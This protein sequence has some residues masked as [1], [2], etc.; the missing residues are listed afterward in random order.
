MCPWH[1]CSGQTDDH[2][3]GCQRIAPGSSPRRKTGAV[4]SQS[5]LQAAPEQSESIQVVA[6]SARAENRRTRKLERTWRG[7][8]TVRQEK[9][10][11]CFMY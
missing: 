4:R 5:H 2:S 3:E 11:F 6:F 7:G 8:A 9:L 1:Q 10:P